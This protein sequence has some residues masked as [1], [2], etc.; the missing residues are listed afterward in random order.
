MPLYVYVCVCVA[1]TKLKNFEKIK[2][3]IF[4]I[5]KV[6]IIHLHFQNINIYKKKGFKSNFGI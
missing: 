4:N 5:K 3:C 1:H 6:I 2:Y